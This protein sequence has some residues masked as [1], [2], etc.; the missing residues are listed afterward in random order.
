MMTQRS[1]QAEDAGQIPL[2]PPSMQP[3]QAPPQ[4]PSRLLENP[5]EARDRQLAQLAGAV[6]ALARKVDAIDR[7]PVSMADRKLALEVAREFIAVMSLEGRERLQAEVAVA[8][9]LTG[10]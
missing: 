6:S 1:M 4:R 2:V 5:D 10:E 8:R 9:Y 3:G 7:P